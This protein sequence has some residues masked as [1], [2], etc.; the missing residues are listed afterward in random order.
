M[1][2]FL[3]LCLALAL[4]SDVR[5]Q[6][7]VLLGDVVELPRIGNGNADHATVA[8]NSNGDLFVAWH[9]QVVYAGQHQVEGVLM[10]RNSALSWDPPQP[11]DV[12]LLGD[13]SLAVFSAA[14]ECTKP[15]VVAVGTDFIVT[16]PRNEPH[17][18][19]SQLET[20]MVLVPPSGPAV[21][22]S[23][24]PG[25]GWLVDPLVVGGDAGLMPDLCAR[26]A[27][28]GTAAVAYA[29][30][31]FAQADL[32]EYDLRATTIDFNSSPPVIA[33]IAVLATGIPIDNTAFAPVGGRVV[34]D[35]VEDDFGHLVIAYEHHEIAVHNGLPSDEGHVVVKRV[36][37]NAG[38]WT[39]LEQE[40]YEGKFLEHR[41]RRP[42]LATSHTDL[43]NTVSI[44]WIEQGLNL[45]ADLE[46]RYG[47]L[48]FL[49]GAG[50]GTVTI[51][52]IP[53]P[54]LSNRDHAHPVP[55]HA[56]TFRTLLSSR[57]YSLNTGIVAFSALPA[58]PE[59]PL[60][61]N[62]DWAWRPATD[63]LEI[64]APGAVDSRLIPVVYEG[65]NPA[66]TAT[67]IYAQLFRR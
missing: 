26:A 33:P 63:L 51:T 50:P 39:E 4:T 41:Q 53:F 38:V 20:A 17:S 60:P 34:P 6:G 31:T 61:T 8:I 66:G 7:S 11:A 12:M 24:Q 19:W 37:E 54:N 30:E 65:D 14:E 48:E 3:T 10:R 29:H 47:E 18:G 32:R 64:G 49:G 58:R 36:A 67:V 40:R 42:N 35:I 45:F 13:P 25:L 21:V 1:R 5:G 2:F 44:A 28:P 56:R 59:R 15:D 52:N 46:T 43:G 9:C 16:W 27:L 62:V 22:D 55:I 57:W 23:Q